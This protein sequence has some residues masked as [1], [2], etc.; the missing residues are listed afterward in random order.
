MIENVANNARDKLQYRNYSDMDDSD[1]DS[2]YTPPGEKKANKKFKYKF[3]NKSAGDKDS[4]SP[5]SQIKDTGMHT[6]SE[7]EA[8]SPVKRG[9]K[10]KRDVLSQK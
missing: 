4:N 2:D 1:R 3:G 9:R 7:S 8:G 10:R 5:T 6:C